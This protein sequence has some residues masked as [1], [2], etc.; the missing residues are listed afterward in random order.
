MS[1]CCE[2]WLGRRWIRL[3][4]NDEGELHPEGDAEDRVLA[5]VD[6]KALVPPAGEDGA[7]DVANNEH[8]QANVVHFVVVVVIVDREKDEANCTHDR[9]DDAYQRVDL[10]PDRCVGC[11]LAGMA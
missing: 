1:V 8:A 10:L 2:S 5:V 4:G 9:S 6:S 3:T 11:K 7:D